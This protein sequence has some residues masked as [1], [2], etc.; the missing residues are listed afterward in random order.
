VGDEAFTRHCV[1]QAVRYDP[2]NY[3]L[4]E[5][6]GYLRRAQGD[7]EGAREAFATMKALRSW[8]RPRPFH[9]PGAP[10]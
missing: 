6:V 5:R 8:K 2:K 9:R 4:W 10:R 7:K 1:E 3:L